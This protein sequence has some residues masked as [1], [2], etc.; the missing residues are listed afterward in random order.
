MYLRKQSIRTR[1]DKGQL[2][3]SLV[4]YTRPRRVGDGIVYQANVDIASQIGAAERLVGQIKQLRRT[5]QWADSKITD[6]GR[7]MY[8]GLVRGNLIAF[9]Q[10][11]VLLYG[12]GNRAR[13]KGFCHVLNFPLVKVSLSYLLLTMWANGIMLNLTTT[14]KNFSTFICQKFLDG[15][16]V[17][18]SKTRDRYP[19]IS[20]ESND[21][22]PRVICAARLCHPD[23]SFI[24]FLFLKVTWVTGT[25]FSTT[26]YS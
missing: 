23:G 6:H 9:L 13:A 8:T 22:F 11:D 4:H 24:L 1:E 15:H 21:E 26:N 2:F 10:S 7:M 5:V 16:Q 19:T 25:F 17:R 20:K 3:S 12:R 14:K 18:N